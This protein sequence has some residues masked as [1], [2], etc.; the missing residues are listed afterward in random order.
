LLETFR[1]TLLTDKRTG[2]NMTSFAKII[3]H[4]K[5]K[6]ELCSGFERQVGRKF[7]KLKS[8]L[9]A[10]SMSRC[11]SNVTLLWQREMLSWLRHSR[12]LFGRAILTRKI[13]HTGL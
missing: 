11:H 13:G 2:E 3:N 6:S 1:V 8:G 4:K 10:D 9:T 7:T 5:F 12:P